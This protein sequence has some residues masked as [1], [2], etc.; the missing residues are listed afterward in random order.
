MT[1]LSL[2]LGFIASVLPKIL[3]LLSQPR[4]EDIPKTS[5]IKEINRAQNEQD[6]EIA[7][8]KHDADLERLL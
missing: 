6:I 5:Y 3:D 8:A 2:I 7:W 4:K 1:A